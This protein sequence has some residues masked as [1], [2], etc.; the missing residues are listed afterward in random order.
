MSLGWPKRPWRRA[1]P[2]PVREVARRAINDALW[3]ATLKQHP[4]LS[5][6]SEIDLDR[7]RKLCSQFLDTKEFTGAGGFVVTDAVAVA[8]AAQACLPIL[9]LGLH[10]YDDFVGIVMHANEVVASREVTDEFGLVHAYEEV[11]SGEAVAGGPI[12]LSW[13]DAQGDVSSAWGYN[14]V[15]HE[16]AHVLDLANGVADGM[17]PL[18]SAPER[19]RWMAVM[20]AEF[21]HFA[22]LVLCGHDTVMD[23]YGAESIDE[24]FA[25]A[26]ESFF[27]TPKQLEE[28]RPALYALL[29]SYYRPSN[30]AM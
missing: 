11:L 27:V 14:V 13:S 9:H 12:M 16:F 21:D 17:P 24:F 4:C 26:S 5:Q 22:A 7:L 6:Q 15:I 23:P 28:S 3:Q 10:L 20:Q 30:P 25:V 29:A 18:P 19:R 8:V 2:E 1:G